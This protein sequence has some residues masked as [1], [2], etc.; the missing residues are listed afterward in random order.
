MVAALQLSLL[1]NA[2]DDERGPARKCCYQ[3][4]SE[5]WMLLQLPKVSILWLIQNCQIKR[6]GAVSY[7]TLKKRNS[8][9]SFFKYY[10]LPITKLSV[11]CAD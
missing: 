1:T 3:Y 10:P 4:P 7:R 8:G 11:L 6:L 9:G 2:R 5:Q